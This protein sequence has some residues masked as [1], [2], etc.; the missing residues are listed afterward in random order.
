MDAVSSQLYDICFQWRNG[1]HAHWHLTVA[2]NGGLE[3][4]CVDADLLFSF[5]IAQCF[6]T[7]LC[8]LK[9]RCTSGVMSI[10]HH[11]TMMRSSWQLPVQHGCPCTWARRVWRD[12][13]L[14]MCMSL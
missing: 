14:D 13:R 9:V 10:V 8:S 11:A 4:R 5:V 2:M 3:Q 1:F 7:M 12:G 6:L